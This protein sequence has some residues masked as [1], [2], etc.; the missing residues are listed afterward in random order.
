MPPSGHTPSPGNGRNKFA[1]IDIGS[2]AVRLLLCRVFTDGGAPVFKKDTWIRIPLRLGEDAFVRGIIGPEKIDKLVKTM[3]GFKYIIEAYNPLSYR[4]CAT[5]AM[6]EAANAQDIL[7]LVR[8]KS[9][10]DIEI[11]DR[12]KEAEIICSNHIE[13]SLDGCM[14]YLYIDVGGGSTEMTLFSKD[15]RMASASFDLG[16]IR[17]LKRLV[18]HSE[19]EAVKAWLENEIAGRAPVAAIGS[20]GNINKIFSLSRKKP[21]KSLSLRNLEKIEGM[22]RSV[23]LRERIMVLGLGQDRADVI[24]PALKIYL[25]I[26]NW[27][28]IRKIFIPQIGLSDGLIHILFDEH[29]RIPSKMG[30]AHKRRGS[31]A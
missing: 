3:I 31:V 7:S 10:I 11:V 1:A 12:R 17:I 22:L 2:N 25:R 14:S 15:K 30:S 9:G 23:T 16:T 19:W 26:M 28:G 13:R 21:G 20:G 6:R 29:Q 4:A 18:P 24:I 27:A 8:N 5:S